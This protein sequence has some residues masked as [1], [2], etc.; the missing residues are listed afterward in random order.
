MSLSASLSLYNRTFEM[1]RIKKSA[2]YIQTGSRAIAVKY[3]E[4]TNV[5]RLDY[6]YKST[7]ILLLKKRKRIRKYLESKSFKL[8]YLFIY[9]KKSEMRI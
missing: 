9:R 6:L 1:N 5:L 3:V 2:K 4:L 8:K 7:H